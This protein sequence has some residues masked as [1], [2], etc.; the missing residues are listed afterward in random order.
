MSPLDFQSKADKHGDGVS[1]M[2]NR[3]ITQPPA[4]AEPI[5]LLSP[6]KS[7]PF[8]LHLSSFLSLKPCPQG[9]PCQELWLVV[10][11]VCLED[12]T[13]N[14]ALWVSIH[15]QPPPLGQHHGLLTATLQQNHYTGLPMWAPSFIFL[16]RNQ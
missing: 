16:Q 11:E 10:T 7:P 6:G 12:T 9:T 4:S 2:K 3:D 15:K 13:G 14:E 5:L 8:S 1:L